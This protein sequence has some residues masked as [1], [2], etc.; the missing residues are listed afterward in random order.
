[1]LIRLCV[2]HLCVE[3]SPVDWVAVP[4]GS[5]VGLLSDREVVVLSLIT[6]PAALLVTVNT[7]CSG[8]RH[9]AAFSLGS[10]KILCGEDGS[11]QVQGRSSS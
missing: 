7:Q 1:M 6:A 9:G 3:S 2:V 10:Q 8:T 4:P 11:W 5:C